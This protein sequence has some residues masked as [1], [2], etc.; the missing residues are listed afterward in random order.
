MT[1]RALWALDGARFTLDRAD[2]LDGEEPGPVDLVVP[3]F[4]VEHDEGLLLLDTGFAPE[5][6]DPVAAFGEVG[7]QIDVDPRRRVDA[8]LRA[9]GFATDD[10][11]H[12]VL[13]HVHFDHTGGLR[14]FP[15]ARFLRR[16]A[17]TPR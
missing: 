5:D 1:A 7:E 14:L 13:S 6:D 10:V 17:R 8:Q 12:V 16:S 4:L 11:T 9:H 15:R 3:T 2:M